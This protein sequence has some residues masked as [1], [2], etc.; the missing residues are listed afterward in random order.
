MFDW[1]MSFDLAVLK[2]LNVTLSGP[3]MD[4]FW[5]T[6]TDLH[7]IVWMQYIVFPLLLGW[8]VYIYKAE[9][10]KPL[11]GIALAVALA[12]TFCYR[13]LKKN[14]ERPRPLANEEI[15]WL[16]KIGEAHGNSFPS[17]HAANC[18]AAATVLAHY[19]RRRRYLFYSFA[20]LIAISRPALGVHYP[21]DA[22]AGAIIGFCVG[23]LVTEILLKRVRYFR[24]PPPVSARDA[25]SRESR[26]RTRRLLGL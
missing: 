10:L 8:L 9:I 20:G 14:I 16:R 6:V 19:F 15:T 23:V 3:W 17:N 26:L 21:S 25:D 4:V 22:I 18:F 1:V 7:K 13:V 5:R 2:F 24:W 12:D 11:I